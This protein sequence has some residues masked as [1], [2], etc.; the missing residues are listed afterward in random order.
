MLKKHLKSLGVPKTHFLKEDAMF[1]NSKVT[2][3]VLSVILVACTNLTA[4]NDRKIQREIAELEAKLSSIPEGNIEGRISVLSKLLDVSPNNESYKQKL[5]ELRER[6]YKIES[7]LMLLDDV[8]ES[9]TEKKLFYY[10]RLLQFDP[11]NTVFKEKH[12]F[13]ES[14]H[15]K[16]IAK[17]PAQENDRK[18]QVEIA[19]L[20]AKL[21]S[22]PE[23]NIEGRISVLSKLLDVSPNNE[24]YK[25]KLAELRER[26]Y[27]IESFLMLLD[28]VPESDTEKKLFYYERLLQFDPNNTVFKEK[29]KFYESKHRKE[30]AKIPAHARYADKKYDKF[31]RISWYISKDYSLFSDSGDYITA[32]VG[33]K[34]KQ[35][36]W[37][38]IKILTENDDWL[39]VHS[40][41]MLIDGVKYG[42]FNYKIKRDNEYG[43]T[44][45]WCDESSDSK[46]IKLIAESKETIIRFSGKLYKKDFT[47]PDYQKR[48]L[49]EMILV[50]NSLGGK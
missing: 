4:E 37:L 2:I 12:K 46:Q 16:E 3:F 8:P 44:W 27:K 42:P 6:Q 1:R 49:K 19:E 32:Y 22:I 29:H 43:S 23:G 34:E 20:E 48:I 14:K 47:V 18:I 25:Q 50:Y 7:F 21:S 5:A 10:E 36:P 28:D 15:R 39:F 38:M 30:I 13:Y 31:D 11:N 9:D 41:S 45:E 26:Q 35:I 17:I 40:I 24:S 33:K